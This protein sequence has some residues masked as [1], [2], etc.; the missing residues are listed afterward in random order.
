[1]D[2]VFTSIPHIVRSLGEQAGRSESSTRSPQVTS[3]FGDTLK[4]FVHDVNG[5]HKEAGESVKQLVAG[6]TNDLHEVMIAVQKAGVAT[7]LM[8]Q[9][10]GKMLEAY[11]EIMRMQV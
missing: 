1:M 6:E 4:E 9:I 7:E 2:P 3:N 11:R 8:I 5:L 10:R